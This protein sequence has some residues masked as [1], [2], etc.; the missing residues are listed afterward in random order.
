MYICSE[1]VLKF[2][3]WCE[4][5]YSEYLKDYKI[6]SFVLDRTVTAK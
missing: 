2:Y 5:S 4:V 6:K 1:Q 3:E